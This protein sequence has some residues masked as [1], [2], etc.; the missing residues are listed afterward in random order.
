MPLFLIASESDHQRIIVF[1]E[2]VIAELLNKSSYQAK[3]LLVGY[4]SLSGYL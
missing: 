4:F 1:P 2:S 3:K